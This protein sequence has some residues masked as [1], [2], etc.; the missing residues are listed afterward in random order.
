MELDVS[1]RPRPGSG[2]EIRRL[3]D[4]VR[5]DEKRR[6]F[7]SLKKEDHLGRGTVF[8]DVRKERTKVNPGVMYLDSSR[9]MHQVVCES[10]NRVRTGQY[11]TINEQ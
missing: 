10:S 11:E 5:S 7:C 1:G 6:N 9:I 3:G 4:A 8:T 2:G